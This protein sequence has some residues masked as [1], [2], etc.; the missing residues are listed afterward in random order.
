MFMP[1][2]H[3]ALIFGLLGVFVLSGAALAEPF[4]PVARDPGKATIKG[5][6][7][8]YPLEKMMLQGIAKNVPDRS[9]VEQPPYPGAVVVKL[10][11][12]SKGSVD[13]VEFTILPIVVLHTTDDM[14]KVLEFYVKALP[15][16]TKVSQY[17]M[18]YV[19]EGSGE[20]QPMRK[21]A[22]ETPNVGIMKLPDALKFHAMPDAKTE[23]SI[24]YK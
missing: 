3:V 18:E 19:Y 10:Q 23:I 13:G 2:L 1:K 14:Q 4:A 15:D 9:A 20:F 17:G 12:A 7:A 16:W 22:L 21:S 5:D 24:Y 11:P 6:E 8:G